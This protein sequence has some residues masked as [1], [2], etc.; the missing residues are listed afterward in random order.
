MMIKKLAIILS[1]LISPAYAQET[2]FDQLNS[3][4]D[5]VE[6]NIPVPE[7]P[8]AAKINSVPFFAFSDKTD[9]S[10]Y[11]IAAMDSSNRS[12]DVAL[13]GMSNMSIA[14]AM[15][16]ARK[17]G[18][19]VRV[20]LNQTHVFTTKRSEEIQYLM[21]NNVSVRSLK[22]AG[23][24]GIMHNKIA[25]YDSRIL[26]T[27]SYNW[28]LNANNASYENVVFTAD[29]RYL[30]GYQAYF[31][32]MWSYAKD[33]SQGPMPYYNENNLKFIPVDESMSVSF[34]G[35]GFPAYVFSP[36]GGA[37]DSI[38][39]AVEKSKKSIK[40]SVFSFYDTEIFEALLAAKKRGVGIQVVVDRVQ[41]SQ[42]EVTALMIKNKFDFRWS[43][44]YN[45]GVMHNKLGIFDDA[46][47]I[48]GSF[49]WSNTA[50]VYNFENAFI[51]DHKSYLRGFG[52]QFADIYA[53]ARAPTAEE[54]ENINNMDKSMFVRE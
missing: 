11:V 6:I 8:K 20:I 17:R 4:S 36:S 35:A 9:I 33:V 46:L 51:T 49:N 41:A 1:F 24:S 3:Y 5:P 2:A 7:T 25:I 52:E 23:R 28:T 38:L 31:D 15:V 18:V 44:G 54:I 22:G 39:K 10:A 14:E 45:G 21:D 53:K 50:E 48:T 34:N 47:L 42:S 29:A 37:K 13:Y 26:M 12:V 40:V 27:G 16:R 19:L 30:K 43:G 32:W